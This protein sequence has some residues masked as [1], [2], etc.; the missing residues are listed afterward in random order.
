MNF[1]EK[2]LLGSY[3]VIILFLVIATPLAF[4]SC[5]ESYG[6]T[7]SFWLV[8]APIW[9]MVLLPSAMALYNNS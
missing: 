5:G 2:L 4:K 9:M 6:S 8:Y 7:Y 1:Q 3:V